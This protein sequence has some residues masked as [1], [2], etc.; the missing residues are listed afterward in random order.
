METPL[1]IICKIESIACKLNSRIAI[2][3][4]SLLKLNRTPTRLRISGARTILARLCSQLLQAAPKITKTFKWKKYSNN[5]EVIYI[6]AVI[7]KN[8]TTFFPKSY[9]NVAA[10]MGYII[11]LMLAFCTFKGNF[12]RK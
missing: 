2:C 3:S 9:Y 1:N 12:W 10:L 4:Y 6:R 7:C 8:R 11:Y 5:I